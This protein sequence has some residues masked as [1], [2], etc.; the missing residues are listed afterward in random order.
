MTTVAAEPPAPAPPP[1]PPPRA[2]V[3]TGTSTERDRFDW[4]AVRAVVA[5]D[6]RAIRRSKPIVIPMVAVPGLLLVIVPFFIGLYARNAEVNDIERALDRLPGGFAD[7]ILDLPTEERLVVL[8]AYLL[9]PLLLIIPIMVSAVLAGDAFAGEKERRTLETL[10][11]LPI[12]DRELFV[13][14]LLVAYLPAVAV[15][16][17]GFVIFSA[18]Y[19]SVVWSVMERFFLFSW[20]WAVLIAWLAPAVAALALGLLV[21]VSSRAKTAQE[22]QQLGGTVILPLILLFITQ[23]SALLVMPLWLGFAM[24]LGVWLVAA[25]LIAWGA[26]KFTRD[27]L[28][29]NA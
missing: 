18:V 4:G 27:S 12:P 5:K 24:G 3:A 23:S 21:I 20:E 25:A 9:A 6:Y 28:A 8:V 10:L 26:R 16:W 7:P 15:S 17:G 13:A 14:K 1:P 29:T 11:H 19:T 22:A 2:D